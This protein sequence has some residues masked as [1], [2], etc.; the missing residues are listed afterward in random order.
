MM[1]KEGKKSQK[2][3]KYSND[4]VKLMA[5]VLS[6]SENPTWSF[7]FRLFTGSTDRL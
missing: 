1:H 7:F 2:Q 5:L 6:A 3:P 4:P